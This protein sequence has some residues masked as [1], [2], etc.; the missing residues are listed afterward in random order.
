MRI[1]LAIEAPP[2]ERGKPLAGQRLDPT[3]A[4]PA[5]TVSVE[6][7]EKPHVDKK[8]ARPGLRLKKTNRIGIVRILLAMVMLIN[9]ECASFLVLEN[10]FLLTFLQFVT[11]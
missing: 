10:T 3:M 11:S 2:L 4:S 5:A 9:G 1:A 7:E 6:L 8:L